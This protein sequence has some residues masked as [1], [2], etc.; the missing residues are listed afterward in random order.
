[1]CSKSRSLIPTAELERLY[2][3]RGDAYV[4]LKKWQN[5]LDDLRQGI[6]AD[7]TDAILLSKRAR[8][9]EALKNWDA[10]AADWSRAA[11]GNPD[12]AKLLA[13]FAR[14]LAAGG[15]PALAT[16]S[17]KRLNRFTSERSRRTLKMTSSYPN[18]RKSWLTRTPTGD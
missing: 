1:M 15:Q 2:R 12:G 3:R 10:A 7:T 8:A 16:P 11:T 4:G 13:E 17:L 9:Y 14:R 5:A 6:T 18:S